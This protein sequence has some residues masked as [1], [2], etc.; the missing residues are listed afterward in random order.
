M[1]S[2]VSNDGIEW[3]LD[4]GPVSVLLTVKLFVQEKTIVS[5]E[6]P[7]TAW[8]L[9]LSQKHDFLNNH[10]AYVPINTSSQGKQEMR[11]E[12]PSSV[13]AQDMD[14]SGYQVSDL[15][16]VDFYWENDLLNID[17]KLLPGFH[18]P[19]PPTAFDDMEM[20]GS[21]EN[22]I[23]LEEEEDTEN[24]PP[25]TTPVSERPTRPPALLKS[26]SFGRRREN[27]PD[28]V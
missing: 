24:S 16:D 5:Q 2:S 22:T 25:P 6:I 14:T 11:D 23:L 8:S 9:L 17:A 4:L 19:F 15:N 20:A 1:I 10:L 28:Y 27:I 3:S 13:S 18:T 26:C 21:A 7:L 12:L